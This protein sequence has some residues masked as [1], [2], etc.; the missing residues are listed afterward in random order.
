MNKRKIGD[1][2]NIKEFNS[3][4]WITL[5]IIFVSMFNLSNNFNN[6]IFVTLLFLGTIYAGQEY[7]FI[8]Y[9]IPRDNKWIKSYKNK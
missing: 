5:V 2:P 3:N 7:L 1:I 6:F 8:R 4:F 9:K